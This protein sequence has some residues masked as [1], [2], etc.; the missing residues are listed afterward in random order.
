MMTNWKAN[1]RRAAAVLGLATAE[2]MEE[3]VRVLDSDLDTDGRVTLTIT[4]GGSLSVQVFKDS[5]SG[6]YRLQGAVILPAEFTRDWA[7]TLYL[8]AAESLEVVG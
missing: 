3:E 4:S 6:V 8:A 7:R 1:E 5:G 2:T